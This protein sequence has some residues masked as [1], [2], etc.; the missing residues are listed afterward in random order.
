MVRVEN[1]KSGIE[2]SI[3][4]IKR[5]IQDVIDE[6]RNLFLTSSKTLEAVSPLSVLSRGYS[7]LTK[8]ERT[9]G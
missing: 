5:S 8:G 2:S 3:K 4:N 6:K 1:N 9:S 7:I